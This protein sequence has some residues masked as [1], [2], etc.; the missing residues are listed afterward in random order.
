M[1]V[2]VKVRPFRFEFISPKHHFSLFLCPF[3][4][5]FIFNSILLPILR[6]SWW[7][8]T[9]CFSHP[10]DAISTLIVFNFSPFYSFLCMLQFHSFSKIPDQ[11]IRG[12][13]RAYFSVQPFWEEL[14]RVKKG[15]ANIRFH[16][17]SKSQNN[18][19][20]GGN[21]VLTLVFIPLGRALPC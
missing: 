3:H 7:P 2:F 20:I 19:L 10:T 12:G 11:L 17:F 13:N 21:I 8:V 14:Y 4:L 9:A 6:V 15:C 1:S 18:L 5:H 16:L